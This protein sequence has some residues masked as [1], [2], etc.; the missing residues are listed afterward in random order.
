M[1]RIEKPTEDEYA[2]YA[3]QYIGLLPD[4]EFVLDH[5][6]RNIEATR[7][8]LLSLRED[9]L[10]YRYAAAKWTIKEIV[11]H[12]ADDERI[13]AYRALRFARNDTTQLPGFDQDEYTRYS[14]ANQRTLNDLLDELA[15]VRAATLSLYEGLGDDTLK[16]TGVA[17]G[18]VMS[19]RAIAYHIAGHELRH[20]NIIRER[21][22]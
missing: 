9:K 11:L 13:Y 2:P 14:G 12:I 4:D 8:F 20:M 18:N 5:L 3:I 17:S 7:A 6:Q 10:L 16:R 21:Y 1:R 22:I 19:V 15:T